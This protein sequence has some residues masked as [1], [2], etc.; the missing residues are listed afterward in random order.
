MD[1]SGVGYDIVMVGTSWGGLAALR[2]LVSGLPDSLCMAITLVQHRHKD[3]DHLLRTL[4]QE[5][6]TLPVCEVEDKMPIEHGTVYVAPPDYHTLV[7]RGFFSLST[8]APVRYSRPSIDVAFGTAA[9]SYGHRTV[10]IVLTGANADGAEGLRLISDRG[11]LALV[12]DPATAESPTMPR[13]AARAVPRARVMALEE[14]IRFV[15]ELPAGMPEREE[16]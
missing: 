14:I 16:A 8:E 1:H 4:L 12:Q 6:S 7:E 13:A 10:G 5:H 2:A 15:G 11:G 3:S 9:D